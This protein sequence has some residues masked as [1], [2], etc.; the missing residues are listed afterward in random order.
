MKEYYLEII[1]PL[2]I[3]FALFNNSFALCTFWVNK[4]VE[5]EDFFITVL[6]FKTG[7]VRFALLD[8]TVAFVTLLIDFS[9][10][11]IIKFK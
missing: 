9:I 7:E 8:E 2:V 10:L 1:V 6:L 11:A 3:N 5:V 4:D